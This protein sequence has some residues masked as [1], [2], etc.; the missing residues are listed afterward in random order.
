MT[1]TPPTAV[2][3]SAGQPS[4]M[5][6]MNDEVLRGLASGELGC[7][8]MLAQTGEERACPCGLATCVESWEPG[9]GLGTRE[10]FARRAAKESGE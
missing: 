3:A 9:C 5:D 2:G 10:E 1:T 4:N 6:D 7:M 8:D